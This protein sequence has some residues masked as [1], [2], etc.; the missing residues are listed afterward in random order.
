M[1]SCSCCLPPSGPSDGG[2]AA[3]RPATAT[4]R[5][6]VAALGL[7]PQGGEGTTV[8]AGDLTDAQVGRGGEGGEWLLVRSVWFKAAL[9]EAI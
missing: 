4:A 5:Q 3:K 7:V 9:S 2:R 1:H 6:A 8:I